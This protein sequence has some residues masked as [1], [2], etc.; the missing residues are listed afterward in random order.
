MAKK[1]REL[2]DAEQYWSAT[3]ERAG[4]LRYAKTILGPTSKKELYSRTQ[5]S[6]LFSLRHGGNLEQ[7]VKD[8][9][10]SV[11]CFDAVIEFTIERLRS[12]EYEPL[13]PAIV[14][15]L[16]RFLRGRIPAPQGHRDKAPLELRL[17]IANAVEELAI[18]L[19]L[20]KERSTSS[21]SHA[22]LGGARHANAMTLVAVALSQVKSRIGSSGYEAVR[23]I[24]KTARRD[25]KK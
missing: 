8:A 21:R 18:R 15:F 12:E 14:D 3:R 5:E 2:V 19:K 23:Q 1:G 13:P 7:I 24:Y 10:R 9:T 6:I 4:H 16:V 25:Q 20:P 11:C 17:M 22:A